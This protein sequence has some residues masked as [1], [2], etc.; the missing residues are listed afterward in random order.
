MATRLTGPISSM[1]F[2]N[3]ATCSATA[4]QSVAAPLAAISSGVSVWTLAGP[5]SAIGDGDAFAAD[6]VQVD[7]IFLL[8]ALAQ[9]LHGH[10]LLRQFD[11]DA[12][13]AAA[14]I[15][16][17]DGVARAKLPRAS[18]FRFPALLSGRASSAAWAL[19]CSRS[20]L[21]AIQ[22]ARRD[23]WIS[24]PPVLAV[25][26]S[27]ETSARRCSTSCASSRMRC[28]SDCCCWRNEAQI[29]SSVASATLL[30][31]NAALAPSRCWRRFFEVGGELGDLLLAMPRS[32]ASSSPTCAAKRGALL[33]SFLFLRGEA[34]DFVND[35]IDLLMQ[36]RVANFA[37]R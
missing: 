3:A 9:V 24:V 4:F 8:D 14:G 22:S 20:M 36:Q 2:C 30:S 7:L 26:E 18:Q 1:R 15:R 10:V 16:S 29:C 28:S 27:D 19:T 31:V 33:Q 25:E 23:S 37:A 35:C 32:R 5:S 17:S 13:R 34:L 6:V 21:Q 12:C 11:F